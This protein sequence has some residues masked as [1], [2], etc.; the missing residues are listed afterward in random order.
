MYAIFETGGKQYKA[1]AGDIINI[2]KTDISE[3]GK[4]ELKNVLML[5]DEDQVEIGKPNVENASIVGH[6]IEYVKGKK[7]IAF[8]SKRRKGYHRKIGHRQTYMK[9]Q[10]DEIKTGDQPVSYAQDSAEEVT[11][12][13]A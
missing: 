1:S 13:G 4:V 7:I 5:V 10:I 12:N 6:L 3:D 2:E 9:I 8:K 11:N